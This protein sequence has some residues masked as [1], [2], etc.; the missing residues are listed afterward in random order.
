MI[1]MCIFQ[2]KCFFR[3]EYFNHSQN[4][5]KNIGEIFTIFMYF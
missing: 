3:N 2:L 1:I 4:R 5:E